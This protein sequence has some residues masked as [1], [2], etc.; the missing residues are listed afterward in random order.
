M[1]ARGSLN[2]RVA[3][4]YEIDSSATSLKSCVDPRPENQKEK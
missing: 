4:C 3:N 2:G 1:L